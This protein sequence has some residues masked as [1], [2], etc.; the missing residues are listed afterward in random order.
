MQKRV[1]LKRGRREEGENEGDRG[2][3]EAIE[4]EREG[5]REMDNKGV[6]QRCT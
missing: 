2:W 3:I 6:K 5:G 1:K 4:K